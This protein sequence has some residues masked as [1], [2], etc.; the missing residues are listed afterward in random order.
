ML[1][2]LAGRSKLWCNL[3]RV[4]GRLTNLT[5]LGMGAE[6]DNLSAQL[7][8]ELA[9]FVSTRVGRG[10]WQQCKVVLGDYMSY[11]ACGS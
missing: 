10:A 1:C 9:D 4:L 2:V 11:V 5:F 6:R 3:G 8:F 7:G